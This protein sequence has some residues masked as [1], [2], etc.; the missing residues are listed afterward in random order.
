MTLPLWGNS[1]LST[2]TYSGG[3]SLTMR[4]FSRP[5][6]KPSPCFLKNLRFSTPE[7]QLSAVTSA[8]AVAP[9]QHFRDHLAEELILSFALAFVHHP[10]VDGQA[11]AFVI[12][13]KEAH[14]ADAFDRPP[15]QPAPEIAHQ[16]GFT[17][18]AVGLIQ[19]GVVPA[20]DA[21][22]QGDQ[23]ARFFKQVPGAER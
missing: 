18:L 3:R 8:G 22:F 11:H 7:Y 16:V 14:E 12:G 5:I 20:Q 17:F 13:V 19:D 6:K 9:S 23:G 10:K 2:G 1:S 15:V 4:F 21:A